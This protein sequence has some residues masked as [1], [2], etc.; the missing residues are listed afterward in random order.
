M[1]RQ[2]SSRTDSFSP[3]KK[4]VG[5][6]SSPPGMVSSNTE[7]QNFWSGL[8]GSCKSVPGSQTGSPTLPQPKNPHQERT[9]QLNPG[10]IGQCLLT[11]ERDSK[12][13]NC[14]YFINT[15]HR[16][17][18]RLQRKGGLFSHLVCLWPMWNT[19]VFQHVPAYLGSVPPEH[20]T[21]E[22]ECFTYRKQQ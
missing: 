17:T 15:I 12:G 6:G 5:S 21:T 13:R 9:K 11:K 4:W 14:D 8:K 22:K 2:A 19:N 3:C 20:S 18:K 7:M 10:G 16:R 1:G